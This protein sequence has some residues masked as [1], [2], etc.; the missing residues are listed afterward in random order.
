MNIALIG[1]GAIGTALAQALRDTPHSIVGIL[2]RGTSLDVLRRKVPHGASVVTS[3][4]ELLALSPDIV[5]ECAGHEALRS[6]GFDIVGAGTTLIIASIGA[7]ADEALEKRLRE[8]TATGG[9]LVIP[10]GAIGGLDALGAARRAGLDEVLYTGK[11]VYKTDD[12]FEENL[13]YL[14]AK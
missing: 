3:A 1:F 4:N 14:G 7:L 12:R 5:V 11:Q 8:A 6:Y 2:G 13:N 10:S 9:R